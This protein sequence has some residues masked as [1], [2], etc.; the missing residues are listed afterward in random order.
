MTKNRKNAGLWLAAGLILL[1][2]AVMLLWCVTDRWSWPD[3]L[4]QSFSLRGLRELASGRTMQVLGSSVALSAAVAVLSVAVGILTARAIVFYR[5]PGRDWLVF[6]SMLPLIVPGT[7]FGMGIHL[8]FVRVGLSDTVTGVILVHLICTLPYT[9]SLLTDSTRL[10]GKRLE[11]QARVLGASA[12]EAFRSV[13][14]PAL[15]P[16][17]LSA[18]AMAY[19]ISFS[20]YFLT[21]LIG[22]GRVRTFTVVMVPFLQGGDRTLA[23][24]YTALFL[25]VTL[26]VFG[27]FR[28]LAENRIQKQAAAPAKEEEP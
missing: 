2:M 26:A 7:V 17:C 14:L 27:V 15:M 10:I 21:L 18:L 28:A 6:G 5:F 13:T 3:L 1:P 20:Q 12:F 22:G 4:P 19:L 23:A 16:A 24:S 11:E 8:L 25:G 9:V